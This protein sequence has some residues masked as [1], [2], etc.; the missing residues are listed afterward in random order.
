[1]NAVWN[2]VHGYRLGIDIGGALLPA[3][4]AAIVYGMALVLVV[5]AGLTFVAYV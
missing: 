5:H 3:V 1:M 2:H 4:N